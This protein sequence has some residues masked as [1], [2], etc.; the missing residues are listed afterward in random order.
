MYVTGDPLSGPRALTVG[1]FA[2]LLSWTALVTLVAAIR[3]LTWA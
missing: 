1:L 3:R 2:G